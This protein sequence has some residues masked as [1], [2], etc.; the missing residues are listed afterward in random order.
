M[1]RIIGKSH[2][3]NAQAKI[4]KARKSTAA[5]VAERLTLGRNLIKRIAGALGTGEEVGKEKGVDKWQ[6]S[7]YDHSMIKRFQHRGLKRLYEDDDRRIWT[8]PASSFIPLNGTWRGSG[9]SQLG[10]ISVSFSGLKTATL[11]TLI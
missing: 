4:R 10:R 1:E 2:P 6:L 5:V 3:G 7:I 8:S 11:P 9:V